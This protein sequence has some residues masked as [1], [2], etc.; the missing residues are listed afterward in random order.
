MGDVYLSTLACC[1]MYGE[2]R[3]PEPIN[4]YN[5][6]EQGLR[7]RFECRNDTYFIMDDG[8]SLLTKISKDLLKCSW[9]EILPWYWKRVVKHRKARE[10][11]QPTYF[12]GDDRDH[13]PIGDI[14][15]MA[16]EEL[17]MLAEP[18]P[19]DKNFYKQNRWR[20]QKTRRFN[21]TKVSNAHHMIHD[22]Y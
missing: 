3:L 13:R 10:I 8:E 21:V 5:Q 19:G 11:V 7:F 17:L 9:F 1:L 20:C 22:G 2:S 16:A 4:P 15:A 12:A 6:Y 18:F 14:F